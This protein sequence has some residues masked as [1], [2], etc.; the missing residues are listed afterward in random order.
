MILFDFRKR[1]DSCLMLYFLTNLSINFCLKY[2]KISILQT[3]QRV[4]K[5][6]SKNI[7]IQNR[8]HLSKFNYNISY[9][10]SQSGTKF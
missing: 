8:K 2:F 7:G 1:I 10:V 3:M 6:N 5:D 9:F 4:I